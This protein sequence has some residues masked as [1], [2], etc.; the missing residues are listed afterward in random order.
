[1]AGRLEPEELGRLRLL[2]SCRAAC[3]V[4]VPDDCVTAVLSVGILLAKPKI[5]SNEIG[6]SMRD[7]M[8]VISLFETK[9]LTLRNHQVNGVICTVAK[10]LPF[11]ID[12]S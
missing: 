1:V 12:N 5:H 9:K 6:Y 3:T 4:L 11:T 7:Q 2:G 8:F 10:M